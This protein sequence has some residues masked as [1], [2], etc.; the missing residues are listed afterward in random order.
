MVSPLTGEH[1]ESSQLRSFLKANW[2]GIVGVVV[3]VAGILYT[4]SLLSGYRSNNN[5]WL[6]PSSSAVDSGVIVSA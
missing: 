3:G 2:L 5:N 6:Q 1:V 4:V